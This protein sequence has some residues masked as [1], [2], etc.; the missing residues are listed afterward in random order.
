MLAA[1]CRMKTAVIR[2]DPPVDT[3]GFPIRIL[4]DDGVAD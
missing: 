1:R 3:R 2:I 4:V